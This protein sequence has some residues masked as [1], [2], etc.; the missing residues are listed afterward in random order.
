[1]YILYRAESPVELEA[2]FRFRYD[3]CFRD[4]P[5]GYPGLDHARQR[6]FE[7]HDLDS[8]HMCARDA[9]G[10]L[11]AVSTATPADAPGAPA[12]WAAW[13]ALDR[14]RPLGLARFVVSTR[15]VLHREERG[16]ELFTFFYKALKRRYVAAGLLASLH[17]CRPGLVSRYQHL[18]HHACAPAFNLP[19]GQLRQPMLVALNDALSPDAMS[20]LCSVLPELAGRVEFHRLPA[21]D[22]RAY[23]EERLLAAGVRALPEAAL[24]ALRRACPLPVAEGQ[25]LYAGP[26][27]AQLCCILA[28]RFREERSGVL[29]RPGPGA[30]LG[31]DGGRCACAAR[32]E[33]AAEILVFDSAVVRR[34]LDAPAG[35][36]ADAAALWRALGA[37]VGA[38][39]H[40]PSPNGIPDGAGAP[41]DGPAGD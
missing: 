17:Y 3:H 25:T 29:L 14:L 1:M 5:P 4:F 30:F 32:A 26:A 40:S 10:R 38:H 18:G 20:G 22:R 41:G 7:P 19:G 2:V 13:F 8:E 27:E 37:S 12:A 33:T 39:G 23:V 21:A 28:G 36:P 31:L 24:P 9:E 11:V 6:L 15:M 16:G 35:P 34:V